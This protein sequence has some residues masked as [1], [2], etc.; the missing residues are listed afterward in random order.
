MSCLRVFVVSVDLRAF[1]REFVL[2]EIA[3]VL[4]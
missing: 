3:V 4:R 2:I 1:G